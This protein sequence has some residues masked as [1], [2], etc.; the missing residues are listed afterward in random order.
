VRVLLDANVV[1]AAFTAHGLCEA[2]LEVCLDA[3]DL[4]MS[5]E[6][7]DEIGRILRRKIKIP[8]RTV[9]DIIRLLQENGDFHRPASVEAWACRDPNDLH[10]LGLAK[11]GGA[12]CI[13]TG[14]QDL[15]GLERFERCPILTPRQFSDRI[16][17]R[18]IR[19]RTGE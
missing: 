17:G 6:L 11:A 19:G 1:V 2:V 16:H 10:V 4:I 8:G 9:D 3:H 7:L 14:D 15:L 12:Q 5:V 18:R 13:V